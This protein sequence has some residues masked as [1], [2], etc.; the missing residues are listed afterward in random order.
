M[1]IL[2]FIFVIFSSKIL[3]TKI[4]NIS[5]KKCLYYIQDKNNIGRCKLFYTNTSDNEPIY[6][7]TLYA[8]TYFKECG[9]YARSYIYKATY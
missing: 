2:L 5:C 3:S 6:I 9:K 4:N 8:R 1:N 7:K